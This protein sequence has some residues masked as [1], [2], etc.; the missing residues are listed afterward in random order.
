MMSLLRALVRREEGR[1]AWLDQKLA[2]EVLSKRLSM[3]PFMER[4]KL[5]IQFPNVDRALRKHPIL[6]RE[7]TV[8]IRTMST[9]MPDHKLG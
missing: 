1:S 9:H 7:V 3:F 4:M 8:V 6:G 2:P 5:A